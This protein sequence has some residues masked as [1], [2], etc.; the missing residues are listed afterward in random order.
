MLDKFIVLDSLTYT[1][2]NYATQKAE[3]M[4]QLNFQ[5][6]LSIKD[7]AGQNNWYEVYIA[8]DDSQANYSSG[9]QFFRSEINNLHSDDPS[10][11]NRTNDLSYGL[12]HIFLDDKLFDG[13]EHTLTLSTLTDKYGFYF[14]KDA[15]YYLFFRSLTESSYRYIRSLGENNENVTLF[16]E[17]TRVFSNIENGYGI[18]AGMSKFEFKLR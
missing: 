5:L 13:K 9:K 2:I 1:A 15:K 10:I 17:P 6:S 4:V 12:A 18:F 7:K 3:T 14:T 8:V 16:N 11:I